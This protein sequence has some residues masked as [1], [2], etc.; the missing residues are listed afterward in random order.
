MCLTISV[1]SKYT[2]AR[3]R[4]RR[5]CEKVGAINPKK[6]A[7]TGMNGM[8]NVATRPIAE[9]TIILGVGHPALYIGRCERIENNKNSSVITLAINQFV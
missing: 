5:M 9:S 8:A 4:I 7:V 3:Q 2:N 6:I 1:N